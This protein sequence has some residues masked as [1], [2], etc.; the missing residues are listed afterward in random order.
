MRGRE[1]LFAWAG[2]LADAAA[3]RGQMVYSE[4]HGAGVPL[5]H[6]LPHPALLA[7]AARAL[8]RL[9]GGFLDPASRRAA[10]VDLRFLSSFARN[11]AG[12]GRFH[13]WHEQSLAGSADDGAVGGARWLDAR[14]LARQ[15]Q[16]RERQAA[17][18]RAAAAASGASE[19]AAAAA[20][21]DADA[22]PPPA[23]APEAAGP[24]VWNA[25][26][27]Y[28]GL[29][30]RLNHLSLSPTVK[31]VKHLLDR[32]HKVRGEL[33]E[34]ADALAALPGGGLAPGAPG[35]VAPDLAPQWQRLLRARWQLARCVE[36]WAG[37]FVFA[38]DMD[39]LMAGALPLTRAV[40]VAL[41]RAVIADAEGYAAAGGA[42]AGAGAGADAGAGGPPTPGRAAAGTPN[43]RGG[44]GGGGGGG[45]DAAAPPATPRLLAGAFTGAAP[46]QPA[47]V[48]RELARCGG[49]A[50]LPELTPA[51]PLPPPC[52]S[53]RSLPEHLVQDAAELLRW[54]TGHSL[55]AVHA[56]NPQTGNASIYF[57]DAEPAV[58]DIATA[59]LTF[60]G[61]QLHLHNPYLRGALVKALLACVRSAAA[62]AAAT[63]NAAAQTPRRHPRACPPPAP[64]AAAARPSAAAGTCRRATTRRATSRTR[65]LRPAAC[66][67]GSARGP[68]RAR[69]CRACSRGTRWPCRR[70]ARRC[71]SSTSTLR[72][73]GTTTP[74]T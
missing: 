24:F 31:R 18:L 5:L 32:A 42:G 14:N 30:V 46:P 4:L 6:D 35:G 37:A 61:S 50:R 22:A 66:R 55:Q 1:A 58:R 65:A 56:V 38:G 25:V 63:R 70:W 53:L 40:A 29:A 33:L 47:A 21:A 54:L 57:E 67:R 52:A 34:A 7:N 48:A 59:L 39:A 26:T 72:T 60:V 43:V 27:E 20:A 62:G 45:G 13:A 12:G 73:A 16:F 8:A 44:G 17:L 11:G 49:G 51:L 9:C 71:S 10:D 2:M 23:L 41:T 64:R 36:A 69:R 3:A 68:R 74:F 28:F 19:A 15:L